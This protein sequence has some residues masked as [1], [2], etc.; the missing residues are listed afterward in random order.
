MGPS[1]GAAPAGSA[2]GTDFDLSAVYLFRTT[3]FEGATAMN[4]S[5]SSKQQPAV[6]LGKVLKAVAM[7][8]AGTLTFVMAFAVGY[9][10]EEETSS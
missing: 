5:L 2:M 1:S 4:T 7:G 8:V 10:A 6:V 3:P 9:R